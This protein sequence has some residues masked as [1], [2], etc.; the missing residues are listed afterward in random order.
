[1][2]F[3]I[4]R[5]GFPK[6]SVFGGTSDITTAPAATMLPSPMV[7]PGM[8]MAARPIQTLS[9]ITT[10]LTSSS[11]VGEPAMRAL[12]SAG[13]PGESKIHACP[14]ILQCRPIT[15]FFPTV[16]VHPW[17]I[18]LLSPMIKVGCSEKRAAK[19]KVHL[20]SIRTLSP[21]INSPRPCIQ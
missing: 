2:S 14:A 11:A 3:R 5:A 1:M 8:I 19:V 21:T 16:K 18:P 10:G 7:T 15:I 20:P 6:T 17:L 13:C 12:G 4:W 9:S